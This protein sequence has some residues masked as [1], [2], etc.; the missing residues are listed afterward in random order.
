MADT[1]DDLLPPV[2]APSPGRATLP[3]VPVPRAGPAATARTARSG[4]PLPVAAVVATA[5]AAL[6]S[7]APVAVLVAVGGLGGG[8]NFLAGVRA[9]LAGWLLGHGVP[10][11]LAGS[12]LSLVPLSL[13][14]IAAWRLA[15]AGV[16]TSRATGAYRARGVLPSVSAAA[17]VAFVYAGF[18]AAAAAG[19]RTG[20]MDLSPTRAALTCGLFAFLAAAAGALRRS[21][22]LAGRL[23]VLPRWLRDGLRGGVVA[24]LLTVA[25]GAAAAG[26]A[27]ALRGGGASQML[28][29][30]H[31]GVLGQIGVTLLCL[32][33]APNLAIWAS[34][35]LLGPG[36]AIGVGTSVSPVTV[37]LGPVPALPIL[38][39]L[40][41][42]P[43]SGAAVAV[44]SLPL[45]AALVAGVLLARRQAAIADAPGWG[46]LLG[47][48][49]CAAPVA[50]LL[51]GLAGLA[52]AGGLGSGRLSQVGPVAW[53]VGVFAA[54]VAGFGLVVGAT[55][56]RAVL[57]RAR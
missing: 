15:R 34:A 29:D 26:L 16:H 40:P 8:F 39:G 52:S 31:A 50:G 33:Y 3:A 5:L 54:A 21:R 35:Y 41:G 49:A 7:L 24:A 32:A 20:R 53:Q 22:A 28:R 30:Y 18:G 13:A 45:A 17:A 36:V 11:T 4:A 37:E 9:T 6:S 47:A 56:T 46:G 44:L 38:A 55:V 51:V 42:R 14:G 43:L 48:A 10:V 57:G 27:L 25:V 1:P 23:V 19:A 2:D 12:R